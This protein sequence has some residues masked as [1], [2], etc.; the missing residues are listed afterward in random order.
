MKSA[1]AASE[2]RL[3]DSAELRMNHRGEGGQGGGGGG[4]GEYKRIGG[5]PARQCYC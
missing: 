3:A 1:T 5:W 4:W 2:R